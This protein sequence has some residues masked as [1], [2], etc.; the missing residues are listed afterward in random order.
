[1]SDDAQM[2]DVVPDE[3]ERCEGTGDR[4]GRRPYAG[5]PSGPCPDCKGTGDNMPDQQPGGRD[6]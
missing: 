6:E 3:C 2:T 5:G 4:Y 1:M